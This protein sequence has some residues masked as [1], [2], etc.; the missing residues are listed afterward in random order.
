[1]KSEFHPVTIWAVPLTFCDPTDV[2]RGYWKGW[3]G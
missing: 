2:A 1:M 3:L